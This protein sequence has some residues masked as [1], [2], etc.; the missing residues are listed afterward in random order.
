MK[1]EFRD[2]A[3][4]PVVIPLAIMLFIVGLVVL[5]AF[6]LLYNTHEAALV[7][8]GVAAAGI[9]LAI[10]LAASR[11]KLEGPQK[12]AVVA[13]GALPVVL[14]GMFALGVGGVD[15]SLLMINVEPHLVIPEDAPE[16]AAVDS[17]A[18]CFEQ[19]DGSCTPTT[20][21]DMNFTSA[22]E[23][24]VLF[25]NLDE[26]TPHNVSYYELA[27]TAENPDAGAELFIGDI[28][29]GIELRPYQIEEGLPEG[30][31][32]FRCD[33]HPSTM[34]GVATVTI[35]EGAAA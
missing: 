1:T 13:A 33:V 24:V 20:E 18:F 16:I 7:L 3:F 17:A 32:F 30:E 6:I 25:N 23:M 31:I 12:A 27:G 14:G 34:I 28:F 29:P 5:F 9:L 26:G 22:E 35:G 11:D 19:E 8:A 15:D 4:L 21:W 10:A 2:R